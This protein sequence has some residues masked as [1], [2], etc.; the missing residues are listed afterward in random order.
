MHA[1]RALEERRE[2]SVGGN[3]SAASRSSAASKSSAGVTTVSVIGFAAGMVGY[4]LDESSIIALGL[5]ALVAAVL[6]GRRG[7][8]TSPVS[9]PG[10]GGRRAGTGEVLGVDL[11]RLLLVT[12][13]GIVG[14]T[15][16]L[17]VGLELAYGHA[18]GTPI[19]DKLPATALALLYGA[20]L[21]AALGLAVGAVLERV[22][23]A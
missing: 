15:A 17:S 14:V 2:M 21:G 10:Q 4:L 11:S 6:A 12:L 5:M 3:S 23:T 1:L 19:L 16:A 20:G 8:E 18:A 7:L 9:G 22:G 13:L